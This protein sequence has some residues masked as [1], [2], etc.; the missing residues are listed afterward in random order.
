MFAAENE[1][2]GFVVD[3]MT[4]TSVC[5]WADCHCGFARTHARGFSSLCV[6]VEVRLHVE[7]TSEG[8]VEQVPATYENNVNPRVKVAIGTMNYWAV[9][10]EQK[11]QWLQNTP[12]PKTINNVK[13]K[14]KVPQAKL[15]N[16]P[17]P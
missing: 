6:S 5:F 16:F 17:L 11:A 13:Q 14:S 2:W 1:C 3:E 10:A 15:T 8:R 4:I 9:S 7:T 12:E